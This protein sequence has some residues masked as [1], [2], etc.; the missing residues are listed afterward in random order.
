MS[1]TKH[2]LY[3]C[4]YTDDIRFFQRLSINKGVKRYPRLLAWNQTSFFAYASPASS[5]FWKLNKY[6]SANSDHIT[7]PDAN[8]KFTGDFYHH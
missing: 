5:V 8:V 7:R 3:E 1:I 4:I 6:R 2:K